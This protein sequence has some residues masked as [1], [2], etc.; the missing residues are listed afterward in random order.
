VSAL[1]PSTWQREAIDGIAK[2][3]SSGMRAALLQLPT[4]FGKSLVAVKV[5][6]QLRRRRPGLRL[7]VVLPK[8]QIPSGWKQALGFTEDEWVPMFEPLRIRSVPGTVSFQ[9]RLELKRA[10]L[11][12]TRGWAPALA[13]EIAASPHLVVVDEV[14]RHQSLLQTFF[15]VFRDPYDQGQDVIERQLSS[16]LRSPLR[17]RRAWPKWLL[18]SATP[19]NP[20]SLDRM[21]PVDLKKDDETDDPD[22]KDEEVLATALE[23]THGALAYLAGLRH[24]EWF[25]AHVRAAK[26]RLSQGGDAPPIEIPK[27][28]VVWPPHVRVP[29]LRPKSRPRWQLAEGSL[30][31]AQTERAIRHL[32]HTAQSIEAIPQHHG[33]RRATA[34]R[35]V[36]SGGLLRTQGN[37]IQGQPYSRGLARSVATA[38]AHHRRRKA[39]VSDKLLALVNFVVAAGHEHVL[40]FCVHRAVARAVEE[41]LHRRLG[42]TCVRAA[43]GDIEDG[44]QRWFNERTRGQTRVLVTT[45]ACSESIDLHERANVLVHYELPW[46]PLRVLQ[47]VGRLWRLRRQDIREGTRPKQPRLPG[48]VHLAHPGSVDE[49]I[50]SRLRRRWGHLRTLGLDYLSYAQAMGT[51]LPAVPWE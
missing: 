40:I 47:R 18:L 3:M 34:E 2:R 46:S 1:R 6:D 14:H 45:D 50:L 48:V 32:V 12:P 4:G 28:L 17:G 8:Q 29:E 36:L 43:I 23:T 26:E 35:L 39:M 19:I 24:G 49:E 37:K 21:D 44:T 5:F 11:S 38:V 16:P 7:I 27:Q 41:A 33:R 31:A 20:V 10:L 9:T 30:P 42:A 13:R 15:E 25:D 22:L 51:R